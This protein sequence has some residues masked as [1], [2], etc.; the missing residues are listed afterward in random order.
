[1]Y[2]QYHWNTVT[3]FLY[4]HTFLSHRSKIFIFK[5]YENSVYFLNLFDYIGFLYWYSSIALVTIRVS[6]VVSTCYSPTIL[7]ICHMNSNRCA[8]CMCMVVVN[9]AWKCCIILPSGFYL[10]QVYVHQIRPLHIKMYINSTFKNI[11]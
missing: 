6:S 10:A 2:I 3:S 1:M 5:N 11:Y 7:T 8:P 9:V 4:T